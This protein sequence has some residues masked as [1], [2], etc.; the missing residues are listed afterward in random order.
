VSLCQGC[1][2]FL[3]T[4]NRYLTDVRVEC[5]LLILSL[6]IL[7]QIQ[8]FRE[9]GSKYGL[10]KVFTRGCTPGNPEKKTDSCKFIREKHLK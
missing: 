9:G 4:L 7:G 3:P 2:T 10:P 1:L 5:Y 6:Y 8:D